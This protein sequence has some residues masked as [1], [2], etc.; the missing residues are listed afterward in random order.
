MSA[1]A[2]ALGYKA[3]EL[4]TA[5]PN[6][7]VATNCNGLVWACLSH[8][9]SV[10][11]PPMDIEGLRDRDL[12]CAHAFDVEGDFDQIALTLAEPVNA[13]LIRYRPRASESLSF[14]NTRYI[15]TAYGFT[16]L[17]PDWPRPNPLGRF[18]G[19]Q[20][21]RTVQFRLPAI[22]VERIAAA[23]RWIVCVTFLT[24]KSGR[25]HT[26]Q[27]IVYSDIGALSPQRPLIS[28]MARQMLSR[29]AHSI[30]TLISHAP[31]LSFEPLTLLGDPDMPAIW[32]FALKRELTRSAAALDGFLNPVPAG[33]ICH[34]PH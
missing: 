12:V 9:V 7:L 5:H 2:Y 22:R 30:Y 6:L 34:R 8:E 15:P 3:D 1:T 18:V 33:D 11:I 10:A 4:R 16:A 21:E 26:L 28:L 32:Y 31:P 23:G 17:N 25:N 29:H 20:P 13:P 19:M 14:C 27:T 24:P